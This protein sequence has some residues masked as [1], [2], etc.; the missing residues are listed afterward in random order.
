MRWKSVSGIA[1]DPDSLER[2][3]TELN[4]IQGRIVLFPQLFLTDGLTPSPSLANWFWKRSG[5][6]K[7]C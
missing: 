6:H 4:E 5:I 7:N 3:T 2:G 1:D